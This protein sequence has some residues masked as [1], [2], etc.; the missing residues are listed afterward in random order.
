MKTTVDISD[1]II[2][3]ARQL[4]RRRNTTL[5]SLIEEG[6]TRVLEEDARRPSAR[7]KP[8]TFKGRGLSAEFQGAGWSAIRDAAYQGRGA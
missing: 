3:R 5:R 6:L 8:V 4:I 1:H 2:N 7:L